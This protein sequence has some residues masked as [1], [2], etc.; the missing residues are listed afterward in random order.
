MTID[1]ES[2]RGKLDFTVTSGMFVGTVAFTAYI[3]LNYES[4]RN[5][6]LDYAPFVYLLAGLLL[7]I[8]VEATRRAYGNPFVA[9]IVVFVGYAL[10][11]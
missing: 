4:L 7:L 3:F 2:L 6:L 10:L 5:R 8:I 9:V 1:R 11:R